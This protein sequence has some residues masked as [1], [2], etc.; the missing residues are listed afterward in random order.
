M[1]RGGGGRRSG[2]FRCARRSRRP[3][4]GFPIGISVASGRGCRGR[5]DPGNLAGSGTAPAVAATVETE[6]GGTHSG[7]GDGGVR[8][9]S[10]AFRTRRPVDELATDRA[11]ALL[12][13]GCCR[14]PDVDRSRSMA[15]T[16]P[17]SL[18]CDL[19]DTRNGSRLAR[20]SRRLLRSSSTVLA[21]RPAPGARRGDRT[22]RGRGYGARH[23]CGDGRDHVGPAQATDPVRPTSRGVLG[24]STGTTVSALGEIPCR[25]P[26]DRFHW[27][28]MEGSI[29]QP[30]RRHDGPTIRTRRAGLSRRAGKTSG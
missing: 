16:T 15:R 11:G 13:S 20:R 8:D 14:P 21:P 3:H 1:D 5:C 12:R 6:M 29:P 24:I 28:P 27:F 10:P 4:E 7:S 25:T 2:G 17:S 22:R 23:G 19:V 9:R 30:S 26:L 18:R